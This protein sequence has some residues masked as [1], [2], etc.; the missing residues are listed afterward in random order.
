MA[1]K[2]SRTASS[3]KKNPKHW[4]PE[5]IIS[6]VLRG[7]G[8]L[9]SIRNRSEELILMVRVGRASE[10]TIGHRQ[11]KPTSQCTSSKNMVLNS[12]ELTF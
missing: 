11:V 9:V 4:I 7:M 12:T 8:G 6:K 10:V 3:R 1:A 5:L 2:Q